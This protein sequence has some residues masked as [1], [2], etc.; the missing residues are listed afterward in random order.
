MPSEEKNVRPAPGESRD[1]FIGRCIG[2][3]TAGGYDSSQAAAICYRIWRE[4]KNA[5]PTASIAKDYMV[6]IKKD[7]A[8]NLYV[9]QATTDDIDRQGER[10][11]PSG[12]R[13]LDRF[14]KT[15]SILYAHN[16]NAF[17]IGKPL[18]GYAG[19]KVL[20]MDIAFAETDL[21]R[22]AKYLYDEGFLSSFS[23]GFLPDYEAIDVIDGVTTYKAWDLLELSGV[24]V[25]A[26]EF[27]TIMREAESRRGAPLAAISKMLT[28][29]LEQRSATIP[30]PAGD[31]GDRELSLDSPLVGVADRYTEKRRSRLWTN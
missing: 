9:I 28:L 8:K 21:G 12:I 16:W 20:L 15:G 19:E 13:N 17:P 29:D 23:I 30:A 26:N 2:H 10:V 24:P 4:G 25:P 1:D 6:L 22:E 5:E 18:D 11:I 14:L 7:A 31:L 27:A 3:Y